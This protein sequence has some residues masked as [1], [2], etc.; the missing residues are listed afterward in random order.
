[1]SDQTESGPPP[2]ASPQPPSP[3]ETA[4]PG[5][6]G[7][8]P[9][10]R[11]RKAVG[12]AIALLAVGLGV[13]LLVRSSGMSEI[14]LTTTAGTLLV[15][16]VQLTDRFPPGCDPGGFL[17]CYRAG[18]GFKILIVW[19]TRKGG[20]QGDSEALTSVTS[21][22]GTA[23]DV[24]VTASDGSRGSRTISGFA[25]DRLFLAFAPHDAASGFVLH[26]AD[27]PPITLDK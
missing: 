3:D 10:Y 20:D 23:S 8:V 21:A 1:M 5:P 15:D 2:A 19:L 26:F 18:P 4:V 6:H 22:L 12:L 27:D 25:A 9:W 24:Y 17:S 7:N 14:E 13:F 11:G 16:Q